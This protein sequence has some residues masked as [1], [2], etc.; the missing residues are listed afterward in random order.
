MNKS[1]AAPRR[2]DA[3]TFEM[4]VVVTLITLHDFLLSDAMS[5]PLAFQRTTLGKLRALDRVASSLEL[6]VPV[7]IFV[8]M[9]LL[10]LLRRNA[11]VRHLAIIFLAWVTL[12][13][14]AKVALVVLIVV[15]R[16]QTGV[17]VL[18]KDTIVLWLVNILLFGVWYWIIDGGGP[19]ARRDGSARRLDFHFPQRSISTP[20]W[21]GWQPGF[22][23]YV[24]LGF[25][26]STQFGLGDTSALSLRAKYLLMLQ[27]TLSFATIVFIASIAIG[28]IK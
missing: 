10:W 28:F 8:V 24:F 19:G 27:V 14:V 21:E 7:V 26:A 17:G 6:V 23:D 3:S 13:L 20:G 5:L 18:L 1:L 11:W 16:P 25:S 12:R 4:L 9:L 15:S 22:W 2:L